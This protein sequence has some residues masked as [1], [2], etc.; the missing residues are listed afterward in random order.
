MGE[1]STKFWTAILLLV[2]MTR[3]APSVPGTD[4]QTVGGF[5]T[6]AALFDVVV[7]L[8]S[9]FDQPTGRTKGDEDSGQHQEHR[10][11]VAAGNS[12]GRWWRQGPG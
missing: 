9:T 2:G 6:V 5:S 11:E 3:F 1:T 8:R 4:D 7:A 12:S 10:S